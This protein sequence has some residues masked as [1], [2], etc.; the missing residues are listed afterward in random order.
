[1][2]SL[3]FTVKFR[4]P[5]KQNF[6]IQAD[7]Q[8]KIKKRKVELV[9]ISD[10][11]LGTYGCR[12]KELVKYMRSIRPKTVVLNGDIIDM[13]QFSKRYWPHSHMKVIHQVIKWMTKGVKVYYI[14]GNH[15]EL[16]RKF[17]GFTL[18]TLTIDNKLM[19]ELD[20]KK[21]WI[22][23][24]DVFDISMQHAR[25]LA[26]L[27]ATGYDLLILI[28]TFCNWLSVKMGRGKI[29]LS[30][31]I[32]NSVKRAVKHI[33]NFEKIAADI[34]IDKGYDYVLCGHIHHP[35]M[36]TITNEKGQVQYLNSGDWIENLTTLEYHKGQ[37]SLYHYNEK[38]FEKDDEEHD[39]KIVEMKRGEIFNK[40]VSEFR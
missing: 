25:W 23:H 26:K 18:D 34:A 29:S 10:V 13:W 40:M 31:T 22:F 6:M 9:V 27:G 38:D 11:H 19:L 20:G 35:E 24:G 14:T 12:A 4:I 33:N 39:E 17:A 3:G 15:D 7:K 8:V 30:K 16:L 28:N 21:V 36:K 37:W 1:M 32:K 5:H 2:T